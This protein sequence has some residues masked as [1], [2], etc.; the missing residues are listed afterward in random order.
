MPYYRC[1]DCD[2]TVY[3][4]VGYSNARVCPE[5]CADLRAAT[6]VFVGELQQRELHR[7]MAREPQAAAVARRELEVLLGALERGQFDRIAL[8]VTELIANSV[9]HAGP[10]AGGLL[11]LDVLV[12]DASVRATVTDGG[13]GFVPEVP[14][15]K[16]PTDGHWGLQLVHELA[17]RWGV[18]TEGCTAVWFELD[19]T[20]NGRQ[21]RRAQG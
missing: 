15:S 19:R 14:A 8:L 1:G 9:L 18:R 10:R 7:E 6:R 2:L 5:C 20:T 21:R 3:S 17:D 4:G 16:D 11:T 12:T 13:N